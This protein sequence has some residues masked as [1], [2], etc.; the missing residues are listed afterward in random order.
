LDAYDPKQ[1][2]ASFC[3]T[4]LHQN[5]STVIFLAVIQNSLDLTWDLSFWIFFLLAGLCIWNLQSAGFLIHLLFSM[6]CTQLLMLSAS[7]VDTAVVV[8][9]KF[10]V[11]YTIKFLLHSQRSWTVLDTYFYFQLFFQNFGFQ[12]HERRAHQN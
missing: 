6:K 1:V 8:Q 2:V 5:I 3:V 10:L 9:V 11:K 7:N 4:L 12:K